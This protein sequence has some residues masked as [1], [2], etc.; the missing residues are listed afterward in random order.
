[1]MKVSERHKNFNVIKSIKFFWIHPKIM[2]FNLKYDPIF[3]KTFSLA[4]QSIIFK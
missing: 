1:M 3:L 4:L 2:K